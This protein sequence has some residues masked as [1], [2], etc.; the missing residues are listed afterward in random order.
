MGQS[1]I[2]ECFSLMSCTA[3]TEATSSIILPDDWVRWGEGC[4]F[5]VQHI[6]KES[7]HFPTLS[8]NLLWPASLW[9]WLLYFM[10]Q[11]LMNC[12]FVSCSFVSL[13]TSTNNNHYFTSGQRNKTKKLS[14]AHPTDEQMGSTTGCFSLKVFL[15]SNI[16]Y[17]HALTRGAQF[18]F[19]NRNNM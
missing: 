12:S 16:Q 17:R 10:I 18:C 2:S 3:A 9:Q 19:F 13:K 6:C 4:M 14:P 11:I 7:T 5:K 8:L 15:I 1:Y